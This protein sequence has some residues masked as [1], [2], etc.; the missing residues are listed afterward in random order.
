[1]NISLV[2]SH[3]LSIRSFVTIYT[4]GKWTFLLKHPVCLYQWYTWWRRK[5]RKQN[6]TQ[7]TPNLYQSMIIVTQ[8][9]SQIPSTSEMWSSADYIAISIRL[10]MGAL[11]NISGY[12]RY[13]KL[14]W[15]D[16]VESHVESYH[17][18]HCLVSVVF[19]RLAMSA[20][21]IYCTYR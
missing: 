3:L 20:F 2:T 16:N 5:H 15:N 9:L 4:F 8:L 10:P 1:M 12:K 7:F 19:L 13:S 14:D 11:A 21:Y 18:G 6:D 17:L